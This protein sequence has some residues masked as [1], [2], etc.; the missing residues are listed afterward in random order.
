MQVKSVTQPH[1]GLAMVSDKGE[2]CLQLFLTITEQ[3]TDDEAI[4]GQYRTMYAQ[5]NIH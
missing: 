1:L 4:Y 2:F 5:A 3:M